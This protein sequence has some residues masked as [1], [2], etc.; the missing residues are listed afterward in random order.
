MDREVDSY[1]LLPLLVGDVEEE[2]NGG[3]TGEGNQA[4][5]TAVKGIRSLPG[6]VRA[7]VV[8]CACV[9]AGSNR[10]GSRSHCLIAS[11]SA[12]TL[13]KYTRNVFQLYVEARIAIAHS[14]LEQD[15]V[16]NE[17]NCDDKVRLVSVARPRGDAQC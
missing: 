11:S 15:L 10:H 2:L 3:T 13:Q 12:E 7:C 9:R 4:R 16:E 17:E 5:W 8:V 14:E 6:C 1:P